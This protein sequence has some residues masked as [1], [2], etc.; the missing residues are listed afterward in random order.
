MVPPMLLLHWKQIRFGLLPFALA[1]FGLPL[2]AVQG[3][4]VPAPEG[5]MS[6]EAYRV[7]GEFQA[8]LPLFPAL[9]ILIGATLALTAWNWDH[10]LRHVY[11]L[12]LPIAR[13]EYSLHK[14]GAGMALA[15]IPAGAFWVGAHL[16]AGSLVLP[17]GLHAYP[18]QL[19]LRFFASIVV[20][21]GVLFAMAAGTVRTTLAVITG[22]VGL[23]VVGSLLQAWTPLLQIVDF[24]FASWMLE[25]AVSAGGPLQVFTGSWMLI[26]V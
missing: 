14:M 9:A 24:D 8:W 25:A 21:Y 10:Q 13:W 19:A 5:A 15:L 2:L 1:A 12:S 18:N 23:V 26:D 17:A 7:V 22:L 4:G 20:T 11:A 6:M 16:A 3:L